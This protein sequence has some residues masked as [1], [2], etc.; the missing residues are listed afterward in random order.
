LTARSPDLSCVVPAFEHPELASR[1]LASLS[2]QR[3]IGLEIVVA[4]DSTSDSIRIQTM[5]V[6]WPTLRYLEGARTG[7]PV[8]NWNLG[9]RAARAP[10][11][12][13]VH[14]DEYLIDPFYLRRALDALGDPGVAAVLGHTR[15]AGVN[16]RSRFALAAA[17]GRGLGK[18]AWLL[19]SLNWIGPTA[20]FVFR[21]GPL[22]DPGLV[23]LADVAFYRQVLKTGRFAT[24][25]GVA[26]GSLGH[27]DAQITARIDPAALARREIA[28]LARGAELAFHRAVLDLRARAR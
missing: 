8:D 21:R 26:V 19:P 13:L 5:S 24:L 11:C 14:H 28:G 12:V 22:F 9:L 2:A 27:H 3:D 18:P 15:V 20:A 7:N 4:D 23:Q 10:V 6:D 17:I 16:R 1:C 25:D